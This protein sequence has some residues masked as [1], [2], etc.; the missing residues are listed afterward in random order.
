MK[1]FQDNAIDVFPLAFVTS[2]FS[3]G[4]LPSLNLA[5]VSLFLSQGSDYDYLLKTCNPTDNT[6][7]P[8]TSLPNCAALAYD[9]QYCQSKG[10]IITISLGGA[11]GSVGFSSDAEA[12]QFAQNIWNIFLGG[13]SSTRPFGSAILDG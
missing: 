6:T 8:G 13:T 10:K 4:G 2:F 5:N 7:F 1:A 11:T 12:Q 9:I 3:T